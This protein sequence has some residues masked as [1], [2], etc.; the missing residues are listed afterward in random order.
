MS[1]SAKQL[2]AMMSSKESCVQTPDLIIERAI[3]TMGAIDLDPCS[4]SAENPNV[5]A[6]THFTIDDDGLAQEWY[7]RVY[8]NPPYGRRIGHW[9]TK[10][11]AEYEAGRVLQA[12]VLLP[13]RTDT[14]WMA[15]LRAFPRCY[16]RGRLKFKGHTAAAPFP[17]VVVFLGSGH[18]AFTNSFNDLGD[19]YWLI[20]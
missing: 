20:S 12:V 4:D 18:R 10:L 8:M 2:A 3:Q 15:K 16:L 11:V 9:V 6:G 19:I 17:S 7:G 14:R 1:L 5:P 13:A